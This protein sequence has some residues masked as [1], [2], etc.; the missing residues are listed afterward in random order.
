MTIPP[1]LRELLAQFVSSQLLVEEL[2]EGLKQAK[3]QNTN[4]RQQ[5]H[6]AMTEA[7]IR[8]INLDDLGRFNPTAR[9]YTNLEKV[10]PSMDGEEVTET[11]MEKLEAWAKE[12]KDAAGHSLFDDLFY[13]AVKSARLRSLVKER[14]DE[15]EDPP[16]GVEYGYIKDIR[17]TRP[18]SQ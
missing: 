10:T 14:I 2:E 3:R 12:Q 8:S 11:G 5:I 4:L 15:G 13:W 6:E 17:W 9:L 16:P 18:T 1:E 7:N